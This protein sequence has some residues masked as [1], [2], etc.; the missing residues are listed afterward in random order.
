MEAI[1]RRGVVRDEG[2][3]KLKRRRRGVSFCHVRRMDAEDQL[4][5]EMVD[6][7]H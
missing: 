5:E 6:G 7:N 3:S 1:M 2:R 4:R